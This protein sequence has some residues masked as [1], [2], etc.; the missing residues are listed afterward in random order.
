MKVQEILK[1]VQVSGLLKNKD[2]LPEALFPMKPTRHPGISETDR[3]VMPSPGNPDLE[4]SPGD[5]ALKTM[6]VKNFFRVRHGNPDGVGSI[7]KEAS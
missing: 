5:R 3:V 7:S 4:R 2:A 6:V 1:W